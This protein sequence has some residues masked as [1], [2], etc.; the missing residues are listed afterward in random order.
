M[1]GARRRRARARGRRGARARGR[2]TTKHERVPLRD[3]MRTV[4]RDSWLLSA[5]VALIVLAIVGTTMQTLG[6]LHLADEGVSQSGVGAAFTVVAVAGAITT[7]T[8][9]RM[10]RSPRPAQARRLRDAADGADDRRHGAAA[11]H[12]RVHRRDGRGRHRAGDRLHGR[13]TRSRPT[14]PSAPGV[15]QGV[16]MGL[17]SVSWGVGALD[18]PGAHRHRGRARERRDRRSCSRARSRSR[19]PWP[20]AGEPAAT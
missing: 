5:N 13:R 12:G 17:L 7:L 1:G 16:A 10:R 18:R 9:A 15:G 6:S 14:A 19:R 8:I 4:S 11:R 3:S 2:R 20:S